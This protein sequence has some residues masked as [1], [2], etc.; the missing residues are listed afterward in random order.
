MLIL[1]T[2]SRTGQVCSDTVRTT[3][4]GVVL[5]PVRAL[6]NILAVTE[7]LRVPHQFTYR[8]SLTRLAMSA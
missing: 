3:H 4:I 7:R 1:L 8:T 6:V 5:E 2:E